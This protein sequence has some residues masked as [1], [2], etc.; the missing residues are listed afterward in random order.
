VRDFEVEAVVEGDVGRIRLAGELDLTSAA[1]AETAIFGLEA[2][3]SPPTIVI[4]LRK[5]RFM[6]STGLR[7]ILAADSRARKT[8]RRL[9]L[10]AGP[11]AVHRVF[12]IALLDGRLEFIEPEGDA[13]DGGGTS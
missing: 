6:D 12:R 4:D 9:R 2:D 11:E 7:V 3:P 10:I 8:G 5:V 1:D 13:A